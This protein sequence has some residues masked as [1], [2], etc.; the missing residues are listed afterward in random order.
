[1]AKKLNHLLVHR[2]S[3]KITDLETLQLQEKHMKTTIIQDWM[4]GSIP[5]QK[6]HHLAQFQLSIHLLLFLGS[7]ESSADY[8]DP[9]EKK[10]HLFST[11][12][13]RHLYLEMQQII[14]DKKI[15]SREKATYFVKRAAVSIQLS[16]PIPTPIARHSY[17]SH[18]TQNLSVSHLQNPSLVHMYIVQVA[19][20]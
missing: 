15:K 8:A 7:P 16:P 10:T 5:L 14:A 12:A 13:C 19:T 3:D 17:S 9:T 11:T 2:T 20:L 18:P 6:W 1:M 4:D